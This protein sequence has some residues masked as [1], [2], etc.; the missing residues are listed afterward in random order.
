MVVKIKKSNLDFLIQVLAER[1]PELAVALDETIRDYKITFE[2][3]SDRADEV[4]D[5]IEEEIQKVGYD[6]NYDLNEKG[7]ILQEISDIFYTK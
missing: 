4:R 1:K 2:I 5:L 7:M 3:N 6:E